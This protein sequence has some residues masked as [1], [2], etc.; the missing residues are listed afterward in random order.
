MC[1]LTTKLVINVSNKKL[2]DLGIIPN[3]TIR[4]FQT[5]GDCHIY[6]VG[7]RWVALNSYYLDFIT[8]Q[9]EKDGD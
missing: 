6:K 7:N 3:S 1:S 9:E 8:F 2:K 5:L 4:H